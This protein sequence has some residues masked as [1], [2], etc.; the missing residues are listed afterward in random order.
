MIYECINLDA[1]NL[2]DLDRLQHGAK[3]LVDVDIFLDIRHG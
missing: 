1:P 2:L 3:P